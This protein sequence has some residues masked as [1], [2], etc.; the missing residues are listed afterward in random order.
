MSNDRSILPLEFLLMPTVLRISG[1]YDQ[2]RHSM[3]A[4]PFEFTESIAS[5]RKRE[6][7]QAPLDGRCTF[8]LTVSDVDGDRVPLQIEESESFFSR[9]MEALQRVQGLEG[10][11]DWCLDFS[12]SFPRTSSGQFNHFP[13]S[14]LQNCA[15]L[16]IDIQ[17]SVYATDEKSHQWELQPA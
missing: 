15:M 5:Q 11:E 10:V 8:D 13:S 3:L 12:W 2:L 6:H 1:P 4:V 16:G 14:L 17:V 7:G 9:H